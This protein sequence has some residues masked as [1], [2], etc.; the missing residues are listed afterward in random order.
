MPVYSAPQE[1]RH[2]HI[3]L[4]KNTKKMMKRGTYKPQADREKALQTES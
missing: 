3:F 1:Q 4:I 2:P